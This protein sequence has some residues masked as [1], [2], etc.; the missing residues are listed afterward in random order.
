MTP[1][2]ELAREWLVKADA[3]LRSAKVLANLAE[4]IRDTG[5]FHCQQ[6]VEK[7]LKALLTLHEVARD[8]V[9][10]IDYLMDLCGP[11][12]AGLERYRLKGRDLTAYA[13]KY[14]YP[15][16]PGE[17]SLEDLA[18]GIECAGWI[19]SRIVACVPQECRP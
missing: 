4:P 19:Y 3:D 8:P 1:T 12:E 11:L 6:A 16:S 2:L 14:R 17:P 13:V 10:S 7:A 15:G 9:H 5:C 18:E